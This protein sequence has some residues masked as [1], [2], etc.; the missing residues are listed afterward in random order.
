MRARTLHRIGATVTAIGL[1]TSVLGGVA[2]VVAGPALASGS[3]AGPVAAANVAVGTTAPSSSAVSIAWSSIAGH[4]ETSPSYEALKNL[5]VSVSQTKEITN[6]GVTI[7][8]SG[9]RPT[10]EGTFAHDFLQVMQCWGDAATGPTPEQCQ[11]GAPASGLSGLLGDRTASRSLSV[12][13]DPGQAY[14]S[15]YL[16]PPPRTNPHLKAYAAPFQTPAGDSVTDFSSYYTSTT[17]NEITAARTGADGT[18]L[19]VFTTQ[20]AL[21]AP[22]LGCGAVTD[23]GA[24]RSCWLVIVP[25]GDTLADGTP[26]SETPDGFVTGSPLSATNW[27]DRIVVP[28]QFQRIGTSCALGQQERRIVGHELFSEAMTSW[29]A[30]LCSTGTTYG[31]SQIGD[32]EA[33]TQIVSSIDG[34]S[35]MGV[36]QKPLTKDQ[37]AG[38]VIAY[39]PIARS[40]I[41]VGFNIDRDYQLSSSRM[42]KNG[43]PVE[44]LVLNAR[45]V[46]K[47][48]TQSYR[49]DVPGGGTSKPITTNPRSIVTDPEFVK[50]NPEFADFVATTGPQGILV[51]L[52]S[53]DAVAQVWAWLRADPYAAAFLAGKTDPWGMTINPAYQSLNLATDTTTDSFPKAD[54]ST[55]RQNDTV[56]EPGYGTLDLLPYM[57]DMREAAYRTQRGDSG[58][59]VVWD[60]YKL[61]AGFTSSGAQLPG[62]R[63]ELSITTLVSADRY[64]LRTAQ[65]VNP[66]G[67]TVAATSASI[68]AGLAAMPASADAAGVKVYDG[69]V[70][71]LGAYPL[72]TLSYAAVSVC[73]AST[74]ELADYAD[75]L[76]YALGAGQVQGDAKGQLL[77]GYLPLTT[78]DVKTGKALVSTLTSKKKVAR[79]CPTTSTPKPSATS[80]PTPTKTATTTPTTTPPTTSAA[81]TDTAT[82]AAPQASAPT[83][84]APVAEV[85][86]EGV[87]TVEP[88]VTASADLGPS[89]L[90]LA[91][92]LGVGLAS[93]LVGPGLMR[94]AAVLEARDGA[95]AAGGPD[96]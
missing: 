17:T 27:A 25:R 87:A 36:V 81:P 41:V 23:T 72:S 6:Q 80:T 91:G 58:A 11:W 46:A 71:A 93:A 77:P 90:G 48:L 10:A 14:D 20:T 40:A 73:Q 42:D 28:L 78:A 31:F 53:S 69:S 88:Q 30:Q 96:A 52:G 19:A 67:D 62:H 26:A 82:S 32:A 83:Q 56:P 3:V 89:R 66:A 7:T 95:E 50:L 4:D 47:L 38:Q 5:Q 63:F 45:L 8:W 16:V 43:T 68:S 35:R 86:D 79:L 15:K 49:A 74:D 22:H 65:L 29:Q 75:F 60:P 64:G 54:L 12:N 44:S 39:T 92:A 37:A 2:A 24:T 84:Q 55:Y 18:G 33:R 94:R 85:T 51:S 61:P 34:A 21:E 13:E 70:R 59:K 9:G 1:T 76:D 57:G